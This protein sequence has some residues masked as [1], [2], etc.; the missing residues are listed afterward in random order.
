MNT[1]KAKSLK[2]ELKTRG[3]MVR[4]YSKGSMAVSVQSQRIRNIWRVKKNEI[5]KRWFL[6]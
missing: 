4:N 5:C 6:F 1:K 3:L 2:I